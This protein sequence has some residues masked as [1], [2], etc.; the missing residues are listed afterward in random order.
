LNYKPKP[1]HKE[2]TEPTVAHIPGTGEHEK[3]VLYWKE[4]GKALKKV[5]RPE[6]EKA[7]LEELA[8]VNIGPGKSPTKGNDGKGVIAGLENAVT[9]GPVNIQLAVKEA[10]LNGF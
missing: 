6:A 4:L 5:T 8:S 9:A 7:I 3:R 2:V 10:Y 1:P